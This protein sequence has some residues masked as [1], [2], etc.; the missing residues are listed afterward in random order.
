MKQCVI[1]QVN[2]NLAALQFHDSPALEIEMLKIF[3]LRLGTVQYNLHVLPAQINTSIQE[4]EL[5]SF[6]APHRNW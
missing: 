5:A 2:I 4:R 6:S 1:G 3:I